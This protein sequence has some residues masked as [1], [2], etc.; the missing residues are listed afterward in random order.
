MH[1]KCSVLILSMCDRNIAF[2]N[3]RY[4]REIGAEEKKLMWNKPV[5]LA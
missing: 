2:S 5:E 1:P 4:Y 3:L